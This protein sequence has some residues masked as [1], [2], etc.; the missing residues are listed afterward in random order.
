MSRLLGLSGL[1]HLAR[2]P[3]Q[4]WL[5]VVGIALGVAV[6][7]AVDLANESARRAF[8]L[9]AE[10]LTGRATHQIVG[11]AAGIPEAFYRE[12][13][14]ERGVRPSAPVV[15]GLLEHR[16]ETLLLTGLDSLAERPFRQL[17][18]G[19]DPNTATRLLVESGTALLSRI[20]A[21]R[22]GIASGDE[23]TV[24][25]AGRAATLRIVGLLEGDNPA[26]M[27]GLLVADIATAQEVLG[28]SGRLDRIDLILDTAGAKR[29]AEALT[30]N[31]RLEIPASRTRVMAEMIEAFQTNLLAMSLLALLVGAFLIYNTMTFSVLRRRPVLATLRIVGVTRASLFRL[32]LLEAALLGLIGTGLGL[33][34]GTAA[35]HYLVQLVTRTVNDL[36]FVL[37]VTQLLVDPLVLV[38]A[39]LVGLGVTL[40][41]AGGPALE[42]ANTLPVGALRRSQLERRVS[43]ALP[44][45][46]LAG[47]AALTAGLWLVWEPG[48][49]LSGGF[50][51]LF[52]VIGGYSLLVPPAVRLLSQAAGRLTRRGGLTARLAVRGLEAS[53]SRTGLA[54]AALA[55]AVAATVGVSIMISSFRT[56][57]AD[58]LDYT[59]AGDIYVSARSS[60]TR[61][62]DA[63]LPAEARARIEA[64]SAVAETSTGRRLT[65][66][67]EYGPV[68]MLALEPASRSHTGFRFVNPPVEQLWSRYRRGEVL[69]VSEPYAYH[70]NLGTG[71]PL[72]LH[73]P[74]GALTLPIGG[75]FYDYGSDRGLITLARSA[76]ARWY[77]DASI[78][79]LGVFLRPGARL[80]DALAAVRAALH[81]LE[82]PIQIRSNREIRARSLEI[83]DRTFAITQVLRLLAVGVA[84]VGVF[85]AL[86][87]LQLERTREQAVLRA[88]GFTPVQLS[89]LTLLQTGIMGLYAGLLS[90]PL[91]WLMSKVLID[92]INRRSFG[93]SIETQLPANTLPEALI[94]ALGAALLAGLYPA[95]RLRRV[96]P[97]QA[98]RE[99]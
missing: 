96:Q 33:L 26:A 24:D 61:G 53:L 3:W 50:T 89:L 39:G 91:G 77:G 47:A 22:L 52:L 80:D 92:I 30:S 71:D 69:L 27:E 42:A 36:Y 38:K 60:G 81:S 76:Y 73:T 37:T 90:L 67:S 8:L 46:A 95:W 11:G 17:D 51:G 49:G 97:A 44:W 13:R 82:Q 99:E 7:A 87:A 68:E 18:S 72:L 85:S 6:I 65:V 66:D 4:T 19:V 15:E 40:V 56:T 94:L 88:T 86:M 83:F 78:S 2:H 43:G 10:S 59:L 31:L 48:L 12:L 35:A 55:V 45:L 41:A 54:I 9:S 98:L 25:V 32:L 21:G 1:R 28:R 74:L 62:V 14:V 29:L 79:T 34:L 57:V 64:L 63:A 58:W 93:W 75:I 5:S 70:H 23:L 20:T 16:G 84:F